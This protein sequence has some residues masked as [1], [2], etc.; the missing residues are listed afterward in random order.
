MNK[1]AIVLVI[2]DEPMDL[3]TELELYMNRVGQVFT[4]RISKVL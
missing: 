2:Y 4:T 3:I 1:C